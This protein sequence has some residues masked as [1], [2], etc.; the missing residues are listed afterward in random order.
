MHEPLIDVVIPV[1][2]NLPWLRMCLSALHA[3]T[4][5]PYRVI[6]VDNASRRQETRDWLHEAG[7]CKKIPPHGSVTVLWRSSNESFS[8]SVNAGVRVG[9]APYVVILNSDAIVTEGWDRALLTDLAQR[10]VGLAGARTNAAAGLQA[11]TSQHGDRLAG[12]VDPS[13]ADMHAGPSAG[14]AHDRAS[15]P[16]LIFFA[17]GLR[18]E[19][20]DEI[21]ELD[22]DTCRGWGG[23]EDL[24][25]SWRVIDRGYRCV[26][27]SAFVLHGCSKTYA[28]EGFTA[29]AKGAAETANIERLITKH[30]ADRV[31]RGL[32]TQ[33]RV[34]LTVF[35]RTN[36]NL[37]GFVESLLR[38]VQV[39]TTHGWHMGFIWP[40]RNLIDH[41]REEVARNVIKLSDESSTRGGVDF[42]Y[43]VMLDDDHTFPPDAI[44][45]LVATGKDVIGAL[46]Y[47]RLT[48]TDPRQADHTACVFRWNDPNDPEDGVSSVDGLEH[49]G[50]HRVD[51]IG[52]GMVAIKVEVLRGLQRAIKAKD[53]VITRHPKK[54]DEAKP[55]TRMFDFD[56]LGED[57][58][59]CAKASRLGYEVWLDSGLILGHLGDPINVDEDYVRRWR[60][61]LGGGGISG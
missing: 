54:R 31:R 46:A 59:F 35:S 3:F 12:Q 58:G 32:K 23:G 44:A 26:V 53:L 55:V 2:D 56:K 10:D 21:G 15:A 20:W 18:R 9:Q 51:A 43:V 24:D 36:M 48:H 60:A 13:N 16:F 47:R 33:P 22:G 45:R 11:A 37:G 30:G 57:I 50:L 40:R 25:Y 6:L 28:A 8:D 1:H 61:Q 42:D 52:F 27:S 7:A 39:L 29:E 41:A 17:V 5:H 4:E 49:T 34:A 14:P 19:V 38:A